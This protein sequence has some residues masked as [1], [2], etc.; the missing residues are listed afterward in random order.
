M[1][2]L[3]IINPF[4]HNG[5]SGKD[6]L[7]VINHLIDKELDFEPVFIKRF[8]D[9]YDLSLK[10]NHNGIK[11]IIAMGGDGTINKVING[12][13]D[14]DGRKISDASFGVI[15]T[16]TSPDFCRSYEIPTNIFKASDVIMRQKIREIPIGKITFFDQHKKQI[17]RYFACCANIGLGALLAQKANAGI[18]KYLGDFAGTFISLLQILSNYKG[19]DYKARFDENEQTI[20]NV[21]NLS[22]GITKYIAS[23]IKSYRKPEFGDDYFYLLK[24]GNV[25]LKNAPVFLKRIYSGREFTDTDYLSVSYAKKI[26]IEENNIHPDVEFDG[27]PAGFLPCTIEFAQDKLPVII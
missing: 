22:V 11:N 9:C 2:T 26:M 3:L 7:K 25:K 15:Y 19:T 5:R 21:I 17:T 27:D 4:S 10:A 18:R 16:G 24:A 14:D 20:E 1:K 6:A 23:G 8:E 13:Y 12:F